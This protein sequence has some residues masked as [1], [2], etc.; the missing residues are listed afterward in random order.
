MIG[1]IESESIFATLSTTIIPF[2]FHRKSIEKIRIENF[3]SNS[4]QKLTEYQMK[5][6]M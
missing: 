3:M 4:K 1:K 6:R 5:N 2:T